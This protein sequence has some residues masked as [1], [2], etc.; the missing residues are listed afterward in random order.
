MWFK[1]NIFSPLRTLTQSHVSHGSTLICP[2]SAIPRRLRDQL[3]AAPELLGPLAKVR[4]GVKTLVLILFSLNIFFMCV[5]CAGRAARR[6][7]CYIFS[8]SLSLSLSLSF[9]LFLSLSLCPCAHCLCVICAGSACGN[10]SYRRNCSLTILKYIKRVW[11]LRA[12]STSKW[13]RSKDSGLLS[14]CD[15]IVLAFW[16]FVPLLSHLISL[17]LIPFSQSHTHAHTFTPF[18]QGPFS[19]ASDDI[20]AS[21]LQ[22]REVFCSIIAVRYARRA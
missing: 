1:C 21:A 17:F 6:N 8:L 20:D 9:S 11:T 19:V 5:I 15:L 18:P 10:T 2:R 22:D 13:R 7:N 3:L 12:A 4:V 14:R 16:C